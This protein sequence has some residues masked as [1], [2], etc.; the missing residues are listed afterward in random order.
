MTVKTGVIIIVPTYNEHENIEPLVQSVSAAVP[1]AKILFVDD[2]SPDG[3]ALKIKELQENDPR[4]FLL[5]RNV[6]SGLGSAYVEAFKEVIRRRLGHIVVTMDADLSHSVEALPAMIAS[7]EKYGFVVGSRYIDGG[8]TAHWSVWRKLLSRLA[9]IYARILTGIGIADL[10]SG[11]SAV[12]TEILTEINLEKIR[13]DGYSFQVELKYLVHRGGHTIFEY[14][15]LFRE[16]RAGK[17]K[18]SG[19]VVVEAIF[20]PWRIFLGLH[21]K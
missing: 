16:R 3:T 12:R 11:F 8:G 18:L 5:E 2:N 9:N 15:I 20:F 13:S 7:T 14:P 1:A 17:S 21:S 6:K 19:K 4:I 10:T